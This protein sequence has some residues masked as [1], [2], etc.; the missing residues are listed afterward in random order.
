MI[1]PKGKVYTNK[2]SVITTGEDESFFGGATIKTFKF[3]KMDVGEWKVKMMAKQSKDAYLVVSDYKNSA[4][5]VLQMPTKVKAN[6]SEYK[7]KNHL[8]HLK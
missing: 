7:L 4:P 1:S 6:K 3:D 5:F 8:W 2:D